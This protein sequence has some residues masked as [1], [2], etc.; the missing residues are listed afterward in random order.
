MAENSPLVIRAL[1][2][3]VEAIRS[4]HREALDSLYIKIMAENDVST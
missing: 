1:L 4:I 3:N 2:H